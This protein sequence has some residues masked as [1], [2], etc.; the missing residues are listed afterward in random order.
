MPP[1]RFSPAR[2]RRPRQ[3]NRGSL[4]I[5]A[6][7]L[8]AIVA[9]SLASYLALSSNSLKLANR[10]FYNNASMNTA[11]TGVEEALWSFNQVAAGTALAT[12]WSSSNWNTSDGVTA[13]ATF[14]DFTLSGNATASVK[15]YVD[16]Y[17]PS[18][19]VQP[20]IVA[21][22]TI[23]MPSESRTLSKTIEVTLRRRSKFAMGL[24]ARNQITFRGNTASVDSWNSLYDDT[25]ALRATPVA[26]ADGI[27][28]LR[29]RSDVARLECRAVLAP[30]SA[31]SG[32]R[33][34]CVRGRP[35]SSPPHARDRRRAAPPSR[36]GRPAG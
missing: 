10:S 12:A 17:N 29:G 2:N 24:V 26:G 5:V 31:I 13:H 28:S 25:G 36:S 22:S 33:R 19:S 23:R 9:I 20:K 7:L 1:L 27:Q 21:Q 15:V 6:M 30:R 35:G 4:L 11:E 34:G 18:G 14:T 32:P 3:S 8:S 16:N